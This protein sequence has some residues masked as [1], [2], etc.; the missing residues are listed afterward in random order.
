MITIMLINVTKKTKCYSW[1]KTNVHWCCLV[2]LASHAAVLDWLGFS[3]C[4]KMIGRAAWIG[5]SFFL[6]LLAGM[7]LQMIHLWDW[8]LEHLLLGPLGSRGSFKVESV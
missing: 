1:L 2:F 7:D 5:V 3:V 4:L 8:F 6:G